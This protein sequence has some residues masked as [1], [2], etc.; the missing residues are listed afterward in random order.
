M[1]KYLMASCLAGGALALSSHPNTKLHIWGNGQYKPR[2]GVSSD[3]LNFENFFPKQIKNFSA[4]EAPSLVKVFFGAK[5]EAGID[6]N[7]QVFTWNKVVINA[8]K[9]PDVDDEIREV[10]KLTCPDKVT[11][12][13]FVDKILFALD[14]K[15]N[16]W[17]W[18]FDLKEDAEARKVPSLSNIKKIVS[19]FGHFLA[20]D[21]DGQVWSMGD[22]TYG[23]CGQSSHNRQPIAPYLQIKYPNPGKVIMLPEKVLDVACGKFHSVALLENGEVW[24]WGRNHK[25]QLGDIDEKSGRAPVVVS[26]VPTRINGLAS[27]KVVKLAAGDMFSV[28][29][30]DE[31]G[32]TEVFGCGLNSRGQLGLGYLTHVTD[33]IKMQ[34]ISNFVYKDRKTFEIRPVSI[35]DLQCGAEHCMALMDVGVIYSWGANEYGEQGNKRRVIQE[36]P[37]L[38][39]AYK[40]KNIVAIAAGDRNSAVIWKE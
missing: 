31:L 7:G 34:N 24:G 19:G 35:K 22:D 16:V 11:Q 3:L 32:D 23:Q 21:N 25:H 27:K 20:L 14:V 38:L 37:A 40:N 26:Y 28:F 5:L 29:I 15:G 33:V 17:Q 1:L 2:A 4:P 39:K 10:K 13:C 12:I 9:L 36:R 6:D 8:A 30:V 18:R